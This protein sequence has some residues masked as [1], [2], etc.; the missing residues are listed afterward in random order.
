MGGQ[1]YYYHGGSGVGGA[2]LGFTGWYNG[3]KVYASCGHGT[4]MPSVVRYGSSY[5][6][7]INIGSVTARQFTTNQAGDWSI[8]TLN[9]GETISGLI[10]MGTSAIGSIKARVNSVLVGITVY[11]YGHT[12]KMWS[13]LEVQQT[14]FTESYSGTNIK[15]LVKCYLTAGAYSQ[16]GDS[17]APYV[18]PNG[19]NWSAVGTHSGSNNANLLKYQNFSPMSHMPSNFAV[20]IGY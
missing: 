9:S 19:S 16:P 3:V 11:T 8:I 18:I 6:T 12:T 7:G 14:N 5:S 17:G 15:G 2:T 10:K 20:E 4:M 1:G 13:S